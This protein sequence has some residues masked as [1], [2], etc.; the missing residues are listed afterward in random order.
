MSV[1]QTQTGEGVMVRG[2]VV[3]EDLA[4]SADLSRPLQAPGG[5][6]SPASTRGLNAE[7]RSV[8]D[9]LS[10]VGRATLLPAKF[11]WS[12]LPLPPRDAHVWPP[13]GELSC[14]VR[15][16]RPLGSG[17]NSI[18]HGDPPGESRTT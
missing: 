4:Q 7:L 17:R 8:W 9:G 15:P 2:V 18:S 6:G 5:A 3:V 1:G 16:G 10:C 13:W 14:T 11:D 12:T